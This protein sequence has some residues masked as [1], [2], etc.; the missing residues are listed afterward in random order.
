MDM[1]CVYAHMHSLIPGLVLALYASTHAFHQF[2][3]SNTQRSVQPHFCSSCL[4]ASTIK[5]L[6]KNCCQLIW[7]VTVQLIYSG[8]IQLTSGFLPWGTCRVAISSKSLVNG[9]F[10]TSAYLLIF[11]PHS[12]NFTPTWLVGSNF[13]EAR[14]LNSWDICRREKYRIHYFCTSDT[15][16]LHTPQLHVHYALHLHILLCH[17]GKQAI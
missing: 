7:K 10:C 5:M 17:R 3:T 2:L 16:L 12:S 14:S 13:S 15:L 11:R 8:S 1:E 6:T 9:L 4:V